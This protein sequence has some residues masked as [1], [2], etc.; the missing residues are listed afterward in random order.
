[1]HRKR[2]R[3]SGAKVAWATALRANTGAKLGVQIGISVGA[4]MVA[5]AA[6]AQSAAPADRAGLQPAAVNAVADAPDGARQAIAPTP[7]SP[8]PLSPAPLS[9]AP[10]SP[11][12]FSLAAQG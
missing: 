12:V 8:D 7:L 2:G 1:M 10:L 3:V 9:P 4:L 5:N 6:L 11:V